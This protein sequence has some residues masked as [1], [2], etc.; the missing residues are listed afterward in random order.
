MG[1]SLTKYSHGGI[2]THSPMPAQVGIPWPPHLAVFNGSY[3]FTF[4]MENNDC[5]PFLDVNVYRE[6][7][8][9]SSS[10]HRKATF[11][12][13]FTNYSAFMP[14]VYKKGLIAT[15]LYRAY[16][17]NSSLI[18]L[19]AEVEKLKDIFRKNGYPIAF[20]DRCIYRFFNKIHEKKVTVH[21]VPKLE[22]SLILPFMGTVSLKVKNNLVRS[23]RNI[24]PFCNIKIVF[25]TSNRISSYFKYK[26]SF[27]KSLLAGVIYK[28]TCAKCNLSYVG[29]TKR[30]WEKRLEEH[31]HI[32]ALTGKP[33]SGL[34]IFAPLQHRRTTKCGE[35]PRVTRD[36]FEIIGHEK[37]WYLLQVKESI[38]INKLGPEL[39]D[40]ISSV[41]LYLFN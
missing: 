37:N 35:S 21:T 4:E 20:I 39:N 18:T 26:D 15:L 2:R 22:V 41:P 10:V 31:T 11:S 3:Y 36:E 29:C 38:L 12:G 27:P 34:T 7:D 19:H 32:S 1:N 17:I 9:F 24:L 40:N 14:E 8:K 33:L 30:Y 6:T 28:Y 25:K 23:F 16:M 5:L 13:V